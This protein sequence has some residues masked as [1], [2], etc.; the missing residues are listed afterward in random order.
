MNRLFR[1]PGLAL[2][3]LVRR[4]RLCR[5]SH[6]AAPAPPPSHRFQIP[7][8]PTRRDT[9][10]RSPAPMPLGRHPRPSLPVHSARRPRRFGVCRLWVAGLD[11]IRRVPRDRHPKVQGRVARG[12]RYLPGRRGFRGLTGALRSTWRSR[13]R[14]HRHGLLWLARRGVVPGWDARRRSAL[15]APHGLRLPA[16]HP[17]LAPRPRCTLEVGLRGHRRPRRP[18][19]LAPVCHHERAVG[20]RPP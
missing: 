20:R 6:H 11:A 5:P 14:R 2:D 4:H 9:G 19:V 7:V 16:A 1:C 3:V 8:G 15:S 17:W 18:P 13:C 12:P 10:L